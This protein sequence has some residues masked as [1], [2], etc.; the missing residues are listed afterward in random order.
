ML[1][2]WIFG[3]NVEDAMGSLRFLIFY[4]VSGV[5]AASAQ[6]TAYPSATDPM[7]GA[8]GL[9]A[10]VL[11][12]YILLFPRANV[13]TL[14]FLG[15]FVTV[16]RIPAAIVLGIWF[17]IQFWSALT[18]GGADAE[19][20]AVWAHVGGFVAGLIL[21]AF[22]KRSELALF[23]PARTRPFTREAS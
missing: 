1:F 14:V 21:V 8:S 7:I 16:V 9:I 18:S 11:G 19:G 3:D 13:R 6:V 2:L 15:L 20:V 10:G 17:V 5:A 22:R 12:A 4:L 23:Q